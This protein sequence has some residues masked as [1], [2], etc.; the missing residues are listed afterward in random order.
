MKKVALIILSL[1]VCTSLLQAENTTKSTKKQKSTS[2]EAWKEMGPDNVGG[3]TNTILID[4]DNSLKLY[5]GSAGGDFGCQQV[6]A[7][8]KRVTSFPDLAISSLYKQKTALYS[9]ERV[10]D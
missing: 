5:A 3:R 10:K 4:K 7:V 2:I 9:S 8:W 6:V 1:T